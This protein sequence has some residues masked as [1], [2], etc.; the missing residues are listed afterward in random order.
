MTK[1]L[2]FFLFG[3]AFFMS[4]SNGDRQETTVEVKDTISMVIA[5]SNDTIPHI[6]YLRFDKDSVTVLPFEIEVNLNLKAKEK[7]IDS[8]ETIVVNVSLTGTPKDTSLYSDDGQF[9]VA[10]AEKEITYGEVAKFDNIKFSKKMFDQL[11]NK[12]VYVTA[13]AYSG[14]KSS[15]NNLLDCNIVADSISNVVN[16]KFTITGKLIGDD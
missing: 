5:K 12:D 8:K 9:Y 16:K 7:I 11:I 14:R 6:S 10:S 4:C 2:T 1:I 3:S 15:P 13:F